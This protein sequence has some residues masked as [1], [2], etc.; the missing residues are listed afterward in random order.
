M[1]HHDQYGVKLSK[2]T[3]VYIYAGTGW[4]MDSERLESGLNP[5]SKVVFTHM[6]TKL[7]K[8]MYSSLIFPANSTSPRLFDRSSSSATQGEAEIPSGKLTVCY[9]TSPSLI[10]NGYN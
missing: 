6:Y 1:I 2:S 10:G 4:E 5:F 3:H 8:Y 7:Y 9:G